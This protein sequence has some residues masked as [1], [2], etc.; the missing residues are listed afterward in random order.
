MLV[1]SRKVGQRII[2]GTDIEITVIQVRG[3]QVRIG[4]TAPGEV[5]VNRAE[6]S[7]R[8]GEFNPEQQNS[9]HPSHDR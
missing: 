4:V 6:V 9:L 3:Q 5:L 2:L 7:A 8:N 1:L